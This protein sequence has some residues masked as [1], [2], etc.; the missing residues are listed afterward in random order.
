MVPKLLEKWREGLVLIQRNFNC[1]V[2]GKGGAKLQ[3]WIIQGG[4]LVV[5]MGSLCRR[6]VRVQTPSPSSR[7]VYS[8]ATWKSNLSSRHVHFLVPLAT[9]TLSSSPKIAAIPCLENR[10]FE[11]R[12]DSPESL[13]FGS[14]IARDHSS[15]R[16]T[17][18][19]LHSCHCKPPTP[20][21]TRAATTCYGCRHHQ[22]PCRRRW[23]V[24]PCRKPTELDRVA[25]VGESR[26]STAAG[27]NVVAS[28]CH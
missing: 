16:W 19:L 23:S 18:S 25:V 6:R 11:S 27:M 20:S 14:A 21:K 8:A 28:H 26:W 2:M 10:C 9:T 1:Q 7:H 15:S 22:S 12:D 3:L 4:I 13:E 5:F 24:Y 17:F